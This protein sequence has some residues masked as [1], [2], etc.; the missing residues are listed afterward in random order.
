MDLAI[1]FTLFALKFV[2]GITSYLLY[3]LN[4]D[5][6]ASAVVGAS[7]GITIAQCFGWL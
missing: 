3:E 6:K 1:Y 5:D 4:E 2:L 7:I